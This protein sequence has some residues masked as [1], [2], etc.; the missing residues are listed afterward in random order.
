MLFDFFFQSSK[1]IFTIYLFIL[2]ILDLFYFLMLIGLSTEEDFAC[3]LNCAKFSQ[4]DFADLALTACAEFLGEY[5]Q[6]V[7]KDIYCKTDQV[8]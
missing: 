8:M 3:D 5:L 6:Y 2:L 4:R 1:L 7:I